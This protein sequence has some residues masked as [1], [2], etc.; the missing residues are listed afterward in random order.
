MSNYNKIT[1]LLYYKSDIPS[2]G[3]IE[4]ME[5]QRETSSAFYH[6][7]KYLDTPSSVLHIK[8]EPT[9]AHRVSGSVALGKLHVITSV[10]LPHVS[11][12]V[13]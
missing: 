12:R 7:M 9:V 10:F 8:I 1:E 5:A 6:Q 4:N 3:F 2:L 13:Y 11:N